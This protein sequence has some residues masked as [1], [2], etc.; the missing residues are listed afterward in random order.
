MEEKHENVPIRIACLWLENR[1]QCNKF[2]KMRLFA[3]PCTISPFVYQF[4]NS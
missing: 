2:A 3:S 1:T 4:E